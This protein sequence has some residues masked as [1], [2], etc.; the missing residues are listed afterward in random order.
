MCGPN[1]E[2]GELAADDNQGV[3]ADTIK[4]GT[5][6]DPGFSGRL[7]LNQELFDFSQRHGIRSVTEGLVRIGMNFHEEPVNAG[8][9]RRPA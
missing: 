7:G 2:G 5:V 1:E 6:A 4:V 8:R 3:S 9:H